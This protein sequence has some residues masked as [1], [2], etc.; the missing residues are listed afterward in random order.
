MSRSSSDSE[1]AALS[2][3]LSMTL[4]FNCLATCFSAHDRKNTHGGVAGWLC[5]SAGDGVRGVDSLSV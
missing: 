2:R 4:P 1:V 3:H 5:V